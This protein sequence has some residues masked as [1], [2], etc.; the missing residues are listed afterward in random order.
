MDFLNKA[1]QSVL[2]LFQSMT[3][4][5]RVTSGIMLAAIVA[6]MFYLF[7]F[8]ISG[9]TVYIYGGQEFS[10]SEIGQMQ[11]AFAA[12]SLNDYEVVG[13]RVRI[14]LSSRDLYNNALTENNAVPN[15][16]LRKEDTSISSNPFLSGP[17]Q[18]Q[19][20]KAAKTKKIR[21][22][23]MDSPVVQAAQVEY[24]EQYEGAPFR[25]LRRSCV[26]SVTPNGSYQ[27][28]RDDVTAIQ[29]TVKASLV[30]I[31]DADIM[32][33]DNNAGQSW[34]GES[35]AQSAGE[36]EFAREKKRY[37]QDYENKIRSQLTHFPG[38]RVGVEVKLDPTLGT[39]TYEK[40]LDTPITI[41]QSTEKENTRSQTEG[42][43][44][45]PG[46]RSNTAATANGQASVAAAG[47]QNTSDVNKEE[48]QMMA[49]G[50]L[51]RTQVAGLV[52]LST[53]VSIGVPQSTVQKLYLQENPPAEGEE[54]KVDFTKLQAFFEE[55]VQKPISERVR[56]LILQAA[57]AG[58]DPY[59]QIVVQMDPEIPLDPLPVPAVTDTALTWLSANWQNLGLMGLG[60]FAV[61]MLRSMVGSAVKDNDASG[62]V[63]K[64]FG[65]LLPADESDDDDEIEEVVVEADGT[66]RIVKRKRH[67]SEEEKV[68]KANQLL[69]R[70]QSREPTLREELTELVEA[71]LDAA[72][73][74]LRS[75]IGE[76]A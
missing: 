57:S 29:R 69:K 15:S 43:G 32:I 5:A 72:A 39:D 67:E 53:D 19:M 33:I 30:G 36:S 45:A 4:A 50:R 75:W 73:S 12:A 47:R 48:S 70:F 27:L 11:N 7:Q 37:E 38:V 66:K 40:M 52:V 63:R 6:S 22:L 34:T 68:E 60:L 23:V 18:K 35:V 16:I 28:N 61:V 8:Q 20:Q 76:A 62:Q 74:V 65:D 2:E 54:V 10:S 13:N 25:E 41:R 24:D 14:P 64:E 59:D 26:V 46:V 3:P 21:D 51:R 17:A 56:P 55:R 42:V 1:Y 71:D 31:R 58:T 49:G 9:G 44:G